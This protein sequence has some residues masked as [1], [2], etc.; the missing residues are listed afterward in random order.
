MAPAEKESIMPLLCY[1]LSVRRNARM[2]KTNLLSRVCSY[3]K[4]VRIEEKSALITD[5]PVNINT[6]CLFLS[7]SSLLV[8][9]RRRTPASRERKRK[10]T[11]Y[12]LCYG[13]R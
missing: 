13:E 3:E 5:M 12:D 2:M 1:L 10:K 4:H 6:K 8:V 7:Y 9:S 11:F